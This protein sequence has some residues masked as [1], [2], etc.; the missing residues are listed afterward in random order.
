MKRQPWTPLRAAQFLLL[1]GYLVVVVYPLL[2][3]LYSSLKTDQAI[4]L[5][6]FALPDAQTLQWINYARAWH[7]ANISRYF[8]NSLLVT[9][10]SVS[11]CILLASMAAY[12]LSRFRVRGGTPIFLLFLAGL[13]IPMQLSI[14][15]L[16]FQM[17]DW[18]LLNSRLGLTIVYMAGGLPFAIFILAGFFRTLPG[19]LYEA[20]VI[21]GCSEWRVYWNIM[22]PLARPGIVTVAIFLF[23]GTWNEYFTAFMFLS[24]A[25]S[26]A[27]R[28]L[29]L[30]LANIAI[31]SQYRSD[32]GV[33][34][35]GLVLVLLPTLLFFVVL[36]KQ[37]VKG[38][39]AGALK[40]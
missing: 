23:L 21:D 7:E 17:R 15:P 14:I 13:M 35:A 11:G 10:A 29:P 32:W 25:G 34:F 28:T 37:I 18:G 20:A 24:G 30:G 16:F 19:T 3:L 9:T 6:P 31:V 2:W 5:N 1:S 33:S 12:A 39:A 4:F 38:I 27:V 8:W 40:G 26:E 22:L 36:Q